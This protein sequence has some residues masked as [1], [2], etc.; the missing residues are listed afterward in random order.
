[1]GVIVVYS[2]TL[3][4]LDSVALT[5]DFVPNDQ[6]GVSL[7]FIGHP[8]VHDISQKGSEVPLEE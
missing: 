4:L 6:T 3:D 1:M 2:M 5:T 8:I 7:E